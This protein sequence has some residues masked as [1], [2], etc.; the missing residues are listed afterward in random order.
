[1]HA[2]ASSEIAIDPTFEL[3]D[4]YSSIGWNREKRQLSQAFARFKGTKNST[5]VI[6]LSDTRGQPRVRKI[7]RYLRSIDLELASSI[8]YNVTNDRVLTKFYIVP[9]GVERPICESKCVE[10]F[11]QDMQ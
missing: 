7:H 4:E 5:L 3:I 9:P 11:G 6:V 2:S 1:M 10:R 8:I